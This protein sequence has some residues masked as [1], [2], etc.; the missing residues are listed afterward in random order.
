MKAAA[1]P[2]NAADRAGQ[3]RLE[4]H[5]KPACRPLPGSQQRGGLFSLVFGYKTL[6]IQQANRPQRPPMLRSA[7]SKQEKPMD[8]PSATNADCGINLQQKHKKP[9]LRARFFPVS[10][11]CFHSIF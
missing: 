7:L 2:A 9:T 10:C 6:P 5:P 8:N 3:G 4:T 1:R 11:S